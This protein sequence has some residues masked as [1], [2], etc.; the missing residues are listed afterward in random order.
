VFSGNITALDLG[1]GFV[2]I[3]D[4]RDQQSYRFSF[5]PT[6]PAVEN[7]HIGQRVRIEAGFDGGTY[8]ANDIKPY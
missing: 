2:T 6:L 4:P 3:Q 5:E 1:S 8:T 7:L